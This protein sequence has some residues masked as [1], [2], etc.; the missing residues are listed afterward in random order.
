[1]FVDNSTAPQVVP[2]SDPFAYCHMGENMGIAYA[3]NYGIAHLMSR[4]CRYVLLLDQDSKID[5]DIVMSLYRQLI[6]GQARAS[7]LVVIAP[8]VLCE[9]S[10]KILVPRKRQ[11]LNDYPDINIVQQVIASGMFLD[12]TALSVIGVKEEALFIDGVDHE[13]CW[14]AGSMGYLIG[15]ST[16]ITMRHRQGDA[17]HRI[18]GLSFKQGSP[19]RLYYQARNCL[20]LARRGYVPLIWKIRTVSA[21]P[22]RFLVN[23]LFFP[24]PLARARYFLRGIWHGVVNKTGKYQ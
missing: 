14:R 6:E 22:I 1:M 9:F 24:Q 8:R 15:Q 10:G 7:K 3:H 13:W 11:P 5:A 17:R 18:L 16:T 20:L 19:V 2:S 12:T 23:S 21:L 4:G